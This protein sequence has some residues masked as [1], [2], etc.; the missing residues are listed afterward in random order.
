MAKIIADSSTLI[1][2]AKCGLLEVVCETFDICVPP[3]VAAEAASEELAKIYPD[4]ALILKLISAKNLTVH[5]PG[6][7]E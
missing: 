4:A 6:S 2:L 3:A 5:D 1:L 7:T